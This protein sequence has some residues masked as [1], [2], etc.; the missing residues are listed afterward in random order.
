MSSR[1]L[2][3]LGGPGLPAG[4]DG[5]GRRMHAGA[6]WRDT[7]GQEGARRLPDQR[8]RECVSWRELLLDIKQRGLEIAPGLAVGDGALRL[9]RRALG[10][11]RTSNPIEPRQQQTSATKSARRR[12]HASD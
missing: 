10:P 3:P 1:Y 11:L 4:P 8:A 6:D 2:P 7:R 12:P 9:P 5:T